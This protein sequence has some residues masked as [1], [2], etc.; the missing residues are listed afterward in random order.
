MANIYLQQVLQPLYCICY[1]PASDI[2]LDQLNQPHI[3]TIHFPKTH[4]NII[5][6]YVPLPFCEVFQLKI[7]NVSFLPH[8]CYMSNH[9][10]SKFSHNIDIS[11]GNRHI[12]VLFNDAFSCEVWRCTVKW[13]GW[14]ISCGLS[15]YIMLQITWTYCG[16][17][18]KS[19][20]TEAV[21]FGLC[22][23]GWRVNIIKSNYETSASRSMHALT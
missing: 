2:I 7:H 19:S 16:E 18:Q 20:V 23:S 17:P 22:V 21:M 13:K 5:L 4:F 12:S 10:S 8:P 3:F 11:C 14:Q 9:Q 1:H 15:Q 6:S